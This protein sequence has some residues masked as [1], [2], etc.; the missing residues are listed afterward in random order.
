MH[1]RK[2]I[3]EKLAEKNCNVAIYDCCYYLFIH[4]EHP[5]DSFR[6]EIL[7]ELR[8]ILI[9][10]FY[11]RARLET[12]ISTDSESSDRTMMSTT[13]FSKLLIEIYDFKIDRR[14]FLNR[15]FN[16]EETFKVLHL[17][18]FDTFFDSG[19]DG[20]EARLRPWTETKPCTDP[21]P[22]NCTLS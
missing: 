13:E 9:F 2:I 10:D 21:K 1:E 7:I 12:R 3:E 20:H 19:F 15:Y 4:K 6:S 8:M 18:I 22:S 17:N 5:S 16:R 11:S 14:I